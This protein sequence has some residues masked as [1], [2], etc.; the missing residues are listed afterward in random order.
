MTDR[1][2][3]KTQRQTARAR[4][5]EKLLIMEVDEAGKG[6]KSRCHLHVAIASSVSMDDMVNDNRTQPQAIRR[7]MS[8]GGGGFFPR[9]RLESVHVALRSVDCLPTLF[10]TLQAPQQQRQW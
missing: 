2:T 8:K 7:T 4:T 5:S 1:E 6:C 3:W 10:N 9:Q